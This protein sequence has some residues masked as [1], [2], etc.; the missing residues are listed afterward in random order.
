ML[1]NSLFQTLRSAWSTLC[2]CPLFK[3]PA[4]S[5]GYNL[6]ILFG[7]PHFWDS[8]YL[9][10]SPECRLCSSLLQSR[11]ILDGTRLESLTWIQF[12]HNSQNIFLF[13]TQII[14]R[15]DCLQFS[16]ISP[17]SVPKSSSCI[18]CFARFLFGFM[19]QIND[20][21]YIAF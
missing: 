21:A 6:D 16:C 3:C 1:N 5:I 14:A 7:F 13:G 17:F 15:E 9:Y 8:L 12:F 11:N 10:S 19:I 4:H 2:I 20:F 18:N